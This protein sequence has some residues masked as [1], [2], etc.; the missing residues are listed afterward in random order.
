[1]E[2]MSF[3]TALYVTVQIV[4]TIGYG[5]IAVAES[6][7]WFMTFYVLCMGA[8]G[9][10]ALNIFNEGTVGKWS[11]STRAM[12]RHHEISGDEDDAEKDDLHTEFENKRVN[13]VIAGA[14]LFIIHLIT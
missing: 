7:R 8:V 4:T 14:G 12:L 6:S 3:V 1:M 13:N 10:Y 5:D 9:A 11:D 2:S